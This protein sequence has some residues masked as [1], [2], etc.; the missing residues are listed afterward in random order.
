MRGVASM[1]G[2]VAVTAGICVNQARAVIEGAIGLES[3]FVRTP[4]LGVTDRRDRPRL[5]IGGGAQYRG[6][7]DL[8]V[9]AELV[10]ALAFAIAA[11]AVARTGAWTSA[12]V[13]GTFAVGFA[14][15]G[16]SSLLARN[17]K[18]AT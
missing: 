14:F 7:R 11:A 12:A 17:K 3:E 4:K 18:A 8:V 2:L 5:A 16:L 10:L 9:V 6:A 13:A 1:P 15:V